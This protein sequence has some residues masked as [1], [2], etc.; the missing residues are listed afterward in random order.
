MI[1]YYGNFT[2]KQLNA[3]ATVL[4]LLDLLDAMAKHQRPV[5]ELY[6]L[7]QYVWSLHVDQ[8]WWLLLQ[9]PVEKLKEKKLCYKINKWNVD[10]C[11]FVDNQY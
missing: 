2:D 11:G 1:L 5:D 9:E 6:Q 10:N 3:L 8:S 4:Y 7:V